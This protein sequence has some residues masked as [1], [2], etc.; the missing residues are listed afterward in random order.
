MHVFLLWFS[1]CILIVL[2]P[3]LTLYSFILSFCVF[4]VM[5]SGILYFV[6]AACT[7]SF[8]APHA[9]GEVWKASVDGCCM[10]QCENDGIVPVEFE[11]SDIPQPVCARAGEIVISLADDNS[12][13]TQRV[14][15]QFY[16]SL[17]YILKIAYTK[18]IIK[19]VWIS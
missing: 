6:S 7:D 15:G 8:G 11:C 13:C 12:C 14:C 18:R 9:L 17:I 16:A 4:F 19:C 5:T 1:E 3:S 2:S 10:Y